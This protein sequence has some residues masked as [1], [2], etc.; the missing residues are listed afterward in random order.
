MG[1]ERWRRSPSLQLE[2]GQTS[3]DLKEGILLAAE[4]DAKGAPAQIETAVEGASLEIASSGGGFAWV[5]W[6]PVIGVVCVAVVAGVVVLVMRR[7]GGRGL[8]TLGGS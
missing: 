4:I 1:T 6:G 7:R 2:E 5:I 3:L 8:G